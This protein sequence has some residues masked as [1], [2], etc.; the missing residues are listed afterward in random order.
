MVNFAA[1]KTLEETLDHKSSGVGKRRADKT[2]ILLLL[3]LGVGFLLRLGWML[4]AKPMPVSDFKEYMLLAENLLEEHRFGIAKP[5]AYWLPGYVFFLA[6]FMIISKS[7]LWLSLINVVLSIIIC[8]E[9]FFLTRFLVNDKAALPACLVC[10]LNPAFIFFSP[11]LAGEHLFGVLVLG[12]IWAALPRSSYGLF[13]PWLSGVLLGGAILTRGEGLFYVPIMVGVCM[14]RQGGPPGQR[15]AIPWRKGLIALSAALCVVL[16]WYIRNIVVLG[17]GAGLSTSGGI[18]FYFA[19][20][21]DKY[22]FHQLPQE[23]MERDEIASQKHGYE[24]GWRYIKSKP[25]CLLDSIVRGTVQLYGPSTY[26]INWSTRLDDFDGQEWKVKALPGLKVMKYLSV[27]GY[28]L[29]LLGV[30]L[31]PLT[32]RYWT[33]LSIF[34]MGGLI[35]CNWFCYAVVFWSKPRYHYI[36]ETIFC[37]ITGTVL[38]RIMKKC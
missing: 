2:L 23:F 22:G 14:W 27:A 20:N 4:Y 24:S 15:R 37:L 3:I 36:A 17:E 11:V 18:N 29:L 28:G 26:G 9:I 12:S 19:H 38:A 25:R 16:A 8:A 5:T 6:I 32:R 34:I 7:V 10:A 30:L 35:F 13:Y 33:S 1:I 31:F 21:P